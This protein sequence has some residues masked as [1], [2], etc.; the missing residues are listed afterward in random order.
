MIS[1]ATCQLDLMISKATCQLDLM[2]S[3]DT[4]QLDLMIS[5]TTLCSLSVTRN[6]STQLPLINQWLSSRLAW[7]LI[8]LRSGIEK[9]LRVPWLDDLLVSL[10]TETAVVGFS[11]VSRVPHS[12]LEWW[13]PICPVNVSLKGFKAPASST[14]PSN[15]LIVCVSLC[16]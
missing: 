13:S 16:Y 6:F 2:I 7:S 5:K 15:C 14:S 4:C 11:P 8:S 1:K 3:R 10:L 12:N 9:H